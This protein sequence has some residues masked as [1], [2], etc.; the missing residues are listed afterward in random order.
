MGKKRKG[1]REWASVSIR[2]PLYGLVGEF[3]MSK[4]DPEIRSSAQF[5]DRAVREKLERDVGEKPRC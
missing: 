4:T 3:V 1:K 5:V 2:I